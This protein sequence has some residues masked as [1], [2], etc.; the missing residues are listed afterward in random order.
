MEEATLR[1]GRFG[2]NEKELSV[3]WEEVRSC[4]REGMPL[5]AAFDSTAAKTG[6]KANSIR[7]HYY[8]ALKLKRAPEDLKLKRDAPFTPFTPTEINHLLRTVLQAQGQGKSVRAC[9]LEMANGDKTG[10]LRL[11]NKYR[12]LLKGQPQ[13]VRAAMEGLQA[14]GLPCVDP[15]RMARRQPQKANAKRAQ[16]LAATLRRADEQTALRI[17]QALAQVL[18]S[19]A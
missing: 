4:E 11:Q 16:V 6:R 12:S 18:E 17:L 10:A 1:K 9:V 5:R 2:W 15:Y 8:T 19:Q 13:L 7:N 3:L 14:Q